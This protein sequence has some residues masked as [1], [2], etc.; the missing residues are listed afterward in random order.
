MST[1]CR[2]CS[3]L[4]KSTGPADTGPGK[5][6]EHR[7]G[8]GRRIAA[9]TGMPQIHSRYSAFL[10]QDGGIFVSHGLGTPL[11]FNEFQ[12]VPGIPLAKQKATTGAAAACGDGAARRQGR[13]LSADGLAEIDS[14]RLDGRSA[15]LQLQAVPFRNSAAP[16]ETDLL[17]RRRV[18]PVCVHSYTV[19]EVR[20]TFTANRTLPTE[21][22]LR[23]HINYHNQEISSLTLTSPKLGSVSQ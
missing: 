7:P 17:T 19:T 2:L 4:G 21:F 1:L 6:T 16:G 23:P 14:A 13:A 20:Q 18:K 10:V 8:T 12:T 15:V 9:V 11:I 22:A 5:S 3:G